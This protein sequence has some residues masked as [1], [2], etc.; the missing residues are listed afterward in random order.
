MRLRWNFHRWMLAQSMRFYQDEFAGRV[1]TKVMQTALA[2][3]DVWFMV[4]EILVF[5]VIYFV[6]WW[7]CWGAST[8]AARTVPGWMTLY[9]VA[10]G[11]FVPS[12]GKSARHR[13]TPAR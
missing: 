5:T 9:V 8:S 7:R 12:L 10:L 3:R 13:P 6:T 11:Y 4:G 2:V 1:A